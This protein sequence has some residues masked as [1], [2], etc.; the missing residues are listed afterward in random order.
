MT[1]NDPNIT[2][3]KR[4]EEINRYKGKLEELKKQYLPTRSKNEKKIN[5]EQ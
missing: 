1:F 4:T 3:E 5:T 2:S